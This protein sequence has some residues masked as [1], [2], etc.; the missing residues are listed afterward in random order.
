MKKKNYL[1]KYTDD[2][3]INSEYN[4][5]YVMSTSTA[6]GFII[7]GINRFEYNL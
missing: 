7:T 5:R 1:E 4:W 6:M 2:V 3:K